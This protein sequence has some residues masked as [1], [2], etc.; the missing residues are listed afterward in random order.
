MKIRTRLLS[1]VLVLFLFLVLGLGLSLWQL[2]EIGEEIEKIASEQIPLNQIV[3]KIATSQLEQAANFEKVLRF[4]LQMERGDASSRIP[5]QEA[6]AEF[7][8]WGLA[9]ERALRWFDILI[10]GKGLQGGRRRLERRE[11]ASAQAQLQRIKEA[12]GDYQRRRAVIFDFLDKDNFKEAK[13]ET[14]AITAEEENLRRALQSLLHEIENGVQTSVLAAKQLQEFALKRVVIILFLALCIGITMALL[15]TRSITVPLAAAFDVA[16]EVARDNLDINVPDEQCRGEIGLLLGAMRN[17]LDAIRKSEKVLE[18]RAA[19]L[20]RSNS[21]LEQFAYI[22]SH[23]LQEPLRTI[24]N[25]AELLLKRHRD[26]LDDDAQMLLNY[27][28]DGVNRMTNLINDLLAYSRVGKQDKEFGQVDLG[29]IVNHTLA[30]LQGAITETGTKIFV[31]PLPVVFGDKLRLTQLFQNLIGNAIKFRGHRI[32]EIA[33][34]SDQIEAKHRIFVRDNGIGLAPRF[35]ERIFQIFQRL[36]SPKE[37]SGT[38]IG[39]AIC[40]KIVEQHN[41]TIWVESIEGEGS[42]FYFT[43]PITKIQ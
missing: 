43:L 18:A 36:H 20:V 1:L 13:L 40:K 11:F 10:T 26:K 34:G 12:F 30:N 27:S 9:I 16:S 22:A 17:M 31:G 39:L 7:R 35:G 29:E 14:L 2:G 5:L 32:V 23:D 21:E 37:Y 38:G 15:I 33:I 42:T 4:G 24:A 28:V 6:V 8:R 3:S 41:G 19:A 25:C